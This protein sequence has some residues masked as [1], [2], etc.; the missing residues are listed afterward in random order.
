MLH[1]RAALAVQ[2]T[3]SPALVGVGRR[4]PPTAMKKLGEWRRGQ[5]LLRV[6]AAGWA[7]AGVFSPLQVEAAP[8]LLAHRPAHE[9]VEGSDLLLADQ[10]VAGD[11]DHVSIQQGS[12][13]AVQGGVCEL[14]QHLQH[15][16]ALVWGTVL[17]VGPDYANQEDQHTCRPCCSM[18]LRGRATT[19][20]EQRP[21]RQEHD[22][23]PWLKGELAQ[24]PGP[25]TPAA[26]A[27]G[28]C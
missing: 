25:C 9:G 2:Q 18:S 6:A 20:S 12:H 23:V 15:R 19:S 10:A 24:L 17:A 1:P 8:V 4:I 21:E 13:P 14:H 3:A 11:V 7:A 27:Q 16:Q 28:L 5:V 26:T 22:D